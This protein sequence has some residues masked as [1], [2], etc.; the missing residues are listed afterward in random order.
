AKAM[1]NRLSDEE[2][3]RLSSWLA[4]SEGNRELMRTIQSS[5]TL[6]TEVEYIR[7]VDVDGAWVAIRRKRRIKRFQNGWKWLSAAAAMLAVGVLS[8]WTIGDGG[9]SNRPD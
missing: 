8:F 2:A 4:E 7:Q 6:A 1:E 9:V 5:E 3:D